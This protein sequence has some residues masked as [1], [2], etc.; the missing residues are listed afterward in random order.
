MNLV[1]NNL[2]QASV[3]LRPLV[4]H[5]ETIH[6]CSYLQFKINCLNIHTLLWC[7]Y[8]WLSNFWKFHNRISWTDCL[9]EYINSHNILC[10]VTFSRKE[11]IFCLSQHIC[12][13]QP[14]LRNSAF[15]KIPRSFSSSWLHEYIATFS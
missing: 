8:S 13:S 10:Q 11:S 4:L 6:L 7:F 5:M 3:L 15:M 9:S 14:I 2:S 1:P 12:Q